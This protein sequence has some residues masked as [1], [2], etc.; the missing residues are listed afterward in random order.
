MKNSKSLLSELIDGI[1]LKESETEKQAIATYLI[2]SIC[3]LS[4][5]DIMSGKSINARNESKLHDAIRRINLNEPLQYILH[6]AHFFGRKFYVDPAVLIPRPETEELVAL[7]LDRLNRKDR[8]QNI[9]DIATGSGCIAI[10]L[11]LE[12]RHVSVSATDVSKDALTV[13]RRNS[14]AL[15]A[16]VNLVMNNALADELPVNDV[17]ILV[18]N[19]P[20][21][22]ENEKQA[23]QSNVVDYEPHLALFVPDNNPLVFY[24]AIVGHGVKHLRSGGLLAVEI[25]ERFGKEVAAMMINSSFRHVE[26]L[27]DLAGKDRFVFSRKGD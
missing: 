9:V 22:A 18:S 27:K 13:A 10:T 17:D 14:K 19:P 8:D 6:E 25:N 11:A 23:M 1:S 7:I 26:L 15:G 20:Y 2:E 3:S 24:E 4:P 16:S 21:I 12:L 5:A